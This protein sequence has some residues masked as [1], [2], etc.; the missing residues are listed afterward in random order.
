[1]FDRTLQILD[2]GNYV[3]VNI[4]SFCAYLNGRVRVTD[5]AK[6]TSISIDRFRRSLEANPNGIALSDCTGV[7]LTHMPINGA[8]AFNSSED[9]VSHGCP[10]RDECGLFPIVIHDTR[11]DGVWMRASAV[12]GTLHNVVIGNIV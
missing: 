5:Y 10:G 8:V 7:H 9:L 4:P 3:I 2:E 1:M 12:S 11:P 6:A